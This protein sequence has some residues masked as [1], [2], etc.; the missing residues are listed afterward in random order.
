M[1]GDWLAK[2]VVGKSHTEK[3]DEA[4]AKQQ[5]LQQQQLNQFGAQFDP[6]KYRF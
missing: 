1:V 3:L 5:E 2:L 4:Q 6:A